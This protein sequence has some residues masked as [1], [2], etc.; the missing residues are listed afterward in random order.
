M[1]HSMIRDQELIV[2]LFAGGGGA[3]Q[4]IYQALG[5]HPDIAINH[6]EDAVAV[7][8][9]NHPSTEHFCASVWVVKPE[10]ACAGRPVGLLWA[11]PDCRHFSRAAGGRPK[12]GKV[13]SLPGVVSTW[14]T[15]VKPRVILVEN[16]GEMIGLGPLLADGTPCPKRIG[17]S[18]NQWVGRLRGLGYAVQWR[19]LCA[20]DYGA[21][22]IRTRLVVQARCDGVPIVWPAPS[23]SK[24]PSLFAPG[25]WRPAADCIDFSIPC[26]SIFTRKRPLKDAT[27]RRIAQGIQ[28]Y[29]LGS[30]D[31]FIIKFQQ[32]SVGQ[33]TSDPLHTVMAGA[34]RFGLVAPHVSTFYGTSTGQDATAPLGSITA[35][36]EHHAVVSAF[37]APITHTGENRGSAVTAPLPTI[38]CAHRGEQALISAVLGGCGG[39]A[40]QSPPRPVTA[41]FGTMT[42][43]ADSVL[44][45]AFLAQHNLDAIGRDA[46]GPLATITTTGAQTQVVEAT[47]SDADAAGA[48]RVAAFLVHYFGSGKQGQDLREPMGAVTTRDRYALVTVEGVRRPIVD[49]GMRMLS[50]P[51]LAAAQSF[52]AD[53]D[54]TDD[55]RLSKTTG[56]RLVGNSVC[57]AFAEA[58]VRAALAPRGQQ[59]EAA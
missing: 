11:S 52:P 26:P 3:S 15:R 39:R 22:T 57:P 7:H 44:V 21:P 27:M 6:D 20:A 54:L 50:L 5:R 45:S 23:H 1:P 43:K 32:N 9:R 38:T 24:S 55:G 36:G 58:I 16:V 25:R 42:T 28:R 2:D 49:I 56:I 10:V 29:V 8:T 46:R 51:E 31:P 18:F 14:A 59:K 13:R 48:E 34:T 12:W 19:E 37:L 53:Y 33:P 30:P 4:G 17:R 40:A 41:P 35:Q 47:L